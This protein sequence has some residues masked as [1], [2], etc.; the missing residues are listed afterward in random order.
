MID[1]NEALIIFIKNPVKGKVKNKLLE[2]KL[3]NA[4]ARATYFTA[5]LSIN[6][7]IGIIFIT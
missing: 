5:M 3:N 7:M 2:P 1:V 4:I 6:R